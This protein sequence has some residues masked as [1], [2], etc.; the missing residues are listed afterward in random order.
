MLAGAGLSEQDVEITRVGFG[1]LERFLTGEIEVYPVFINNEPDTL[2]RQG[3]DAVVIDPHDFG[4]PTLGLTIL[5]HEELLTGDPELAERFLRAT[6]RG[7]LYATEHI[8]EAVEITLRFAESADPDHQS[9]L[10]ETDLRAAARPDGIGRGTLEQWQQVADL[11][12]EFGSLDASVD[13]GEVYDPS[14]V[15]R[16]Y[17]SGALD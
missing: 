8:D 13:V 10:L 2:R 4:V 15:D 17:S 6:L 1:E 9:F 11:L 5:A 14:I 16:I 12:L 7:A 3:V